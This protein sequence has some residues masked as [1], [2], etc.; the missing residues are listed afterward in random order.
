MPIKLDLRIYDNYLVAEFT[1][2][3]ETTN[4][5][6]ESIRLWTEVANKCKEHDLYK[7][8]AISRLNKILSTSNAFAFAEAFKSIGWNP[9][10]KL[11]GVAF[12]KQ[13][14]LQYQRQVTF[15]N[16]FGY[17]CKSFGNTKEAKK[18]LE[19]I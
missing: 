17:Q 8:L 18:W 15:I 12:N 14:F 5:L 9:S 3:R 7:V 4:E 6:E 2:I 16:N 11:A 10:Y 1:G 13:L 19:I